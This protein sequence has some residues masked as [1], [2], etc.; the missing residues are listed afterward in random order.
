MERMLKNL[1]WLVVVI[2]LPLTSFGQTNNFK[3]IRIFNS[4]STYANSP[5]NGQIYYGVNGFR[6]RE[7]GVW[8]KLGSAGNFWSLTGT[9]TLGGNVTIANSTNTVTFSGSGK[10]ISAGD[11]RVTN[12]NG[13]INLGEEL[14][15]SSSTGLVSGGNISIG[16]PTST[17]TVASGVGHVINNTTKFYTEVTWSAFTNVTPSI[18]DPIVH[19]LINSSGSLVQQNTFPTRTQ[20]RSNIYI[21]YI[22]QQG[23]VVVGATPVSQVVSQPVNQLQDY[24]DA[25]GPFNNSGNAL[26]ANGTNMNVNKSAGTIFKAGI[27]F[28]SNSDDPHVKSQSAVTPITFQYCTSAAGSSTGTNTTNFT[29]ANYDNGG[30]ITAIPGS[31]NQAT[32]QRV[33]LYP[34]GTIRVQYGPTIYSSLS[35][36]IAAVPTETF[37]PNPSFANSAILLGY[38]VLTKGATALNDAANARILMAP[39]FGDAAAAAGTGVNWGN[40]GGTITNQTDLTSYLSTN[41]QP[42]SSNLTSWAGVTRASGFDTWAATPSSANLRSLLTDETGTGLAYFQGGALGTPSSGTLT[43]A[44]GLPISTGVSGLGTGVATWLATPSWTN[45]NSAITGTAPYWSLASGGTLTGANTFAMAGNNVNFLN[46]NILFGPTGATITTNTRLEVRGTGTGTNLIQRWADS[47]NTLRASIADDGRTTLQS[48]NSTLFQMRNTGFSNAS[49]Q[50]FETTVSGNQV[51]HNIYHGN[52][53]TPNLTFTV[54][55]TADSR[56]IAPGTLNFYAGSTLFSNASGS[57]PIAGF[58]SAGGL[59][60]L[61]RAVSLQAGTTSVTSTATQVGSVAALEFPGVFWTGSASTIR[62]FY[63]YMAA[64]T[65]TNLLGTYIF[66][67][68]ISSGST[69]THFIVNSNGGFGIGNLTAINASTTRLQVRGIGTS[70]GTLALFEDQSGTLALQLSDNGELSLKKGIDTTTGD[71]ATINA[72]VGRFRKDTSGTTFTLTNS[73]ITANSIISLTPANA[74]IDATAT[75]WTVNAGAGSATITFNAAPT[76]NFDMNF[77]VIN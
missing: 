6:F 32:I 29:G 70:T 55:S 46:G 28:Q 52:S 11:F 3:G 54:A 5:A 76:A 20:R 16:S 56:I 13:N 24:L 15:E 72:T 74:A 7:G 66:G 36:A 21:G 30:T 22:A 25:F 35:N 44:T 31:S 65:S 43:N 14:V 50:A 37:T 39:K 42:L 45:F 8:K 33:Y 62:G 10:I 38:V 4:D 63:S 67:S 17:F 75:G 19:I 9:S 68:T 59:S 47:S 53:A 51:T 77:V 58:S 40:I 48:S 49:A 26:T 2:L 61:S 18:A 57:G 12:G 27:N 71:A 60:P 64:S 73:F 34:S 1:L 69:A 23:G 41:Y